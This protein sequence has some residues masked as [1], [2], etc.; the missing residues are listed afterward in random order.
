MKAGAPRSNERFLQSISFNNGLEILRKLVR[1][2]CGWIERLIAQ[3]LP[4]D[5]VTNLQA[6]VSKYLRTNDR[7]RTKWRFSVSSGSSNCLLKIRVLDEAPGMNTTE[8]FE[9][10]PTASA[11]IFVPSSDVTNLLESMAGVVRVRG[12][13]FEGFRCHSGGF[14]QARLRSLGGG[15]GGTNLRSRNEHDLRRPRAQGRPSHS[16]HLSLSESAYNPLAR[17]GTQFRSE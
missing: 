1:G 13:E 15:M 12:E 8:G 3:T 7:R 4:A 14:Y 2:P 5:I 6:D 11:Q 17:P 16:G 10:S 9:G